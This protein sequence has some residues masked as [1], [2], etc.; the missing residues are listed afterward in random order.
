MPRS[1]ETHGTKSLAEKRQYW[2]NVI[3]SASGPTLEDTTPIIDTTDH[4][5]VADREQTGSVTITKRPPAVFGWLREKTTEI[6]IGAAVLLLG[7]ILF[8]LYGLNREVGELK[9]T[10]KSFESQVKKV[11]DVLSEKIRALSSDLN[12]LEQ[13]IDSFFDR[14]LKDR[15]KSNTKKQE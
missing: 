14:N 11:D 4:S 9:T 1:R 6:L 8:Q 3:R 15:N 7:W 10:P 12:R 2:N 13:R 5:A